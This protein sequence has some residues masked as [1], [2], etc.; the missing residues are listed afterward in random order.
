MDEMEELSERCWEILMEMESFKL[1]GGRRRSGSG[2]RLG[3][4]EGFRAS[5]PPCGV[6]LGDTLQLPK[7]DLAV[8]MRA[9]FEHQRRVQFEG[10]V[11]ELLEAIMAILPGSKWSCLLLRIV[12]QDALSE[13]TKFTRRYST[14]ERTNKEVSEMARKVMREFQEEV[15]EKGLKLSI[16]ETGKEGKSKM[17][18]SCG[19]LE[20]KLRQCSKEANRLGW[21]SGPESREREPKK[22]REGRTAG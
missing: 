14:I 8:A 19:Y 20:E 15:E 18:A 4:G 1:P 10:C 11:V 17:I 5:L 3:P 2:R 21:T 13:V 12:L 9:H 6:G 22:K 7:E 16:T